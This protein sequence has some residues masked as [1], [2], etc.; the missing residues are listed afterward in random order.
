MR[1]EDSDS[2]PD[3]TT[4]RRVEP[5]TDGQVTGTPNKPTA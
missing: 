3:V 5:K 1:I 4:E 2:I